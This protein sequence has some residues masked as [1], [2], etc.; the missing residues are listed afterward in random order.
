MLLLQQLAIRAKIYDHFPTYHQV[1]WLI[2]LAKLCAPLVL[3][4]RLWK[5]VSWE[6]SIARAEDV[7]IWQR[8]VLFKTVDPNPWEAIIPAT[9]A[10]ISGTPSGERRM[11]HSLV[12][13]EEEPTLE[14]LSALYKKTII[15]GQAPYTDF[16]V[17]TP[18]GKKAAKGLP[19]VASV[20]QWLG[21]YKV[22]RSAF[23]M[24]ELAQLAYETHFLKMAQEYAG[25]WHLLVA[26]D[27][28]ARSHHLERIRL[29]IKLEVDRG[30]QAPYGYND[31]KPW[32]CLWRKMVE[33]QKYWQENAR[34]PALQWLSRGERRPE[35]SVR[36]YSFD[37]KKTSAREILIACRHFGIP[38]G[39]TQKEKMDK[40]EVQQLFNPNEKFKNQHPQNGS[41]KEEEGGVTGLSKRK[42]ET[43][44]NFWRK[45]ARQGEMSTASPGTME[46]EIAK[47]CCKELNARAKSR[48]RAC[49]VCH[50]PGHPSRSCP[51]K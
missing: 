12:L 11:K 35:T 41:T 46:T 30:G 10:N 4:P 33:Y 29:Q 36:S 9:V 38:I 23:I 19:R 13:E 1:W 3:G 31:A 45:R 20:E 2:A 15:G 51:Q 8:E 18:F 24:L 42:R 14:Q 49:T 25:A 5:A 16:S 22:M 27:E 26:A 39:Y 17:F 48:E 50:S 40:F 32:D 6:W 34:L 37:E 47:I 7:F 21:P 28:K 43:L 44:Q